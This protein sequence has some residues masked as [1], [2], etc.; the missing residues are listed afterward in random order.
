MTREELNRLL[1]ESP[2]MA[3]ITL[4]DSPQCIRLFLNWLDPEEGIR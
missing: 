4:L 2:P 3:G 1:D